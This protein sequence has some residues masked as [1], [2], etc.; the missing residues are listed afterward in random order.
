MGMKVR[1]SLTQRI[2]P[3]LVASAI[4]ASNFA[5]LAAQGQSLP[6]GLGVGLGLGLL[7][8][9]R[10][11]QSSNYSDPS[12]NSGSNYGSSSGSGS[13]SGGSSSGSWGSSSSSRSAANSSRRAH[14]A[15]IVKYNK[16]VNVFNAQKYEDASVLLGQT[17][18]MDPKMGSAYALLAVCKSKGGQYSEAMNDFVLAQNYGNHYESLLYEEGVCAA[19]LQDYRLARECFQQFL[20]KGSLPQTES[21]E[22]AV[23]IIQHNFVTQSDD[24]YLSEASREGVRRWQDVAQPLKVYIEENSNLP[25]YRPEFGQIV[26]QSF[27]DWAKGTNDKVSFVYTADPAQAQIK[28]AWTDNQADLGDTKELGI[29]QL[30][31][32][33]DGVIESASIK[34]W[35]LTGFCRDD[36]TELLPQAKCVAL[37]EIGHALGLQ[38]SQEPFDTMFPLVPPKGLEFALTKRDLNT[39]TAL[40]SQ[41]KPQMTSM[42]DS[43]LL[44][45]ALKK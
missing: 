16:A 1:A 27:D 28:C 31:F 8:A 29:T 25:G 42:D 13:S 22:K 11:R 10:R 5:P 34:L 7:H 18:E 20:S 23:A 30:I 26:K 37:H 9:A 24:N 41:G 21:A 44:S 32:S 2:S 6:I 3:F 12:A 14:S 35:T 19:H 36:A 45:H 39:V 4:L 43:H 40:Y 17:I 33:T 15:A 38:H